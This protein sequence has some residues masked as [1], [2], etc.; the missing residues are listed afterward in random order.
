MYSQ[1][2]MWRFI[3]IYLCSGECLLIPELDLLLSRR[4]KLS[5]VRG[6][7]QKIP[8]LE[9]L[10]LTE[11]VYIYHQRLQSMGRSSGGICR[12]RDRR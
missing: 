9:I 4:S 2:N 3:F 1:I 10:T 5:Q 12:D 11:R 6:S 7:S 8:G